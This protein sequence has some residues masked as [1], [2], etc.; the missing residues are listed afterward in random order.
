MYYK[1]ECGSD[2]FVRTYNVWQEKI[3]VEVTEQDGEEYW[4]VEELGKVKDHLVGY[5]CCKCGE[6]AQELNDGL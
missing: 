4:G 5:M 3:K 1:C 6:D 2:E